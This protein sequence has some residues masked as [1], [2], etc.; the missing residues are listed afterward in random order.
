M[1]RAYRAASADPAVT[2]APLSLQEALR[3]ADERSFAVQHVL[4]EAA[5][6]SSFFS[7]RSAKG[8]SWDEKT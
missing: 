5:V 1:L 2:N 4:Q 3:L 8:N 7:R 6:A